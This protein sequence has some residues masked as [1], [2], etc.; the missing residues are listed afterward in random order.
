MKF[1][2]YPHGFII[3]TVKDWT[4]TPYYS[5][6]VLPPVFK[7]PLGSGLVW[8]KILYIMLTSY[9]LHFFALF[10]LHLSLSYNKVH[11]ILFVSN[12]LNL[13]KKN[14]C[15]LSMQFSPKS[16]TAVL[17]MKFTVHRNMQ[18]LHN[19]QN[20]GCSLCWASTDTEEDITLY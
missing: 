14:F 10:F 20:N 1:L 7:N 16:L 19:F 18:N 3:F 5:T 4:I 12:H 17:W 6:I 11:L 15:C 2:G 13:L 8:L 9:L